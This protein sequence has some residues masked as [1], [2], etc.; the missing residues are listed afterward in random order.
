[1]GADVVA[2]QLRDAAAFAAGLY[3][4]LTECGEQLAECGDEAKARPTASLVRR[5]CT[6]C[7]EAD[8]H[9]EYA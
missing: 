9:L 2:N 6:P 4:R 7:R 8:R 1:M 5:G 3:E